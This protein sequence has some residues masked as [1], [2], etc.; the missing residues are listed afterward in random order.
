MGET[1]LLI[2][3]ACWPIEWQINKKVKVFKEIRS[4]ISG[5][6]ESELKEK[7]KELNEK[8]IRRGADDKGQKKHYRESKM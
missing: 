3:R 8:L 7:I 4:S 1:E 2:C 6:M 5:N